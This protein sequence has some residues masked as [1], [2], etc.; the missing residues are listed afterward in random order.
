MWEERTRGPGVTPPVK[1][2]GAPGLAGVRREREVRASASEEASAAAAPLPHSRSPSRALK[3]TTGTMGVRWPGQSCTSPAPLLNLGVEEA[4]GGPRAARARGARGGPPERRPAR[5]L[6]DRVSPSLS[7][8]PPFPHPVSPPTVP[9][10][11]RVVPAHHPCAG[12]SRWRVERM[13][14]CARARGTTQAG[15]CAPAG[16]RLSRRL[17]AGPVPPA[18]RGAAA[19]QVDGQA[20]TAPTGVAIRAICRAPRPL[21]PPRIH[22]RSA[23]LFSHVLSPPLPLPLSPSPT[24]HQPDWHGQDAVRPD[25]RPVSGTGG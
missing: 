8:P 12:E 3:N 10:A 1:E 13:E 24:E 11:V 19:S 25:R 14:S 7:P 21:P 5:P 18:S 4:G 22:D 17:V 23:S 16:R 20:Y 9:H 6:L 2:R 15:E